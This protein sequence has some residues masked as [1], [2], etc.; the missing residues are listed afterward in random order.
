MSSQSMVLTSLV[1]TL[2]FQTSAIR[3]TDV[4]GMG[5]QGS[6]G[7]LSTRA[8]HSLLHR[9]TFAIMICGVVEPGF[10]ADSNHR[11]IDELGWTVFDSVGSDGSGGDDI[12]AAVHNQANLT[13]SRASSSDRWSSLMKVIVGS[14]RRAGGAVDIFLCTDKKPAGSWPAELKQ[15]FIFNAHSQFARAR[16]CWQ[17]I[18]NITSGY[19][20]YFK[21]RPD[22]VYWSARVDWAALRTD[23]LYSRFRLAGGIANL[24]SEHF[25]W[26]TC[27]ATCNIHNGPGYSNDDMFWLAHRSIL[28]R[29]T[30]FSCDRLSKPREQFMGTFP[31][32]QE[33]K[34]SVSLQGQGVLTQPFAVTGYPVASIWNHRAVNDCHNPDGRSP[35][36]ID[37]IC[38]EAPLRLEELFEKTYCSKKVFQRDVDLQAAA[39]APRLANNIKQTA[40]AL[41]AADGVDTCCRL[42]WHAEPIEPNGDACLAPLPRKAFRV[43]GK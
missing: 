6:D 27:D 9:R 37:K 10:D 41:C 31:G 8:P 13:A 32:Y 7:S 4:G 35:R 26:N 25:S 42:Q 1:V 16:G 34:F 17:H 43:E 30:A 33:E 20:F 14:M 21:T 40:A 29:V 2:L 11:R 3:V 22:F 38:G 12:P 28:G 19:D 24:T 18:E 5:V 15:M 23:R 39:L 36:V